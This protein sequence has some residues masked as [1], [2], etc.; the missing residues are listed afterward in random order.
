[1]KPTTARVLAILGAIL[2]LVLVGCQ[3]ETEAT[4]PAEIPRE[5]T[6]VIGTV[7]P[8]PEEHEKKLQEYQTFLDYVVSQLGALGIARGEVVLAKTPVEMAKFMRQAKVDIY[9]DTAFP[10]Y[11]AYQLAEAELLVSRWKKGVEKYHS[12]I[13]IRRGSG[14]TSLDDLKGRMIAF[15]DPGSTSAYFLPKAELIKRGYRLTEK[16]TPADPVA[17]DEIGY[18]FSMSDE[19]VVTDVMNGTAAAG[20]QQE[21]EIFQYLT[22]TGQADNSAA[23]LLVTRD[24]Y[25]SMVLVRRDLNP[26]LKAAL[27]QLLLAMDQTPEGLAVLKQF[28]KTAAF[29]E[30]LPSPEAA[31]GSIKEL[32]KFVEK[33]IVQQ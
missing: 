20:A 29:G 13:F 27:K 32:S 4:A 14:I 18:Y 22:E 17:P 30:F 5:A 19:Q 21:A 26:E 24:I 7:V 8:N 9:S 31:L 16:L 25:R 1:M 10:S 23:L 3:T 15:E 2:T 33:E 28:R 12:T 11:I 6:L